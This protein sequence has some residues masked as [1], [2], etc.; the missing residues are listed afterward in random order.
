MTFGL[1]KQG[2][3][4]QKL[5]GKD[6]SLITLTRGGIEGDNNRAALLDELNKCVA[7]GNVIE[8][9][10]VSADQKGIVLGN[11]R[12]GKLPVVVSI[13]DVHFSDFSLGDVHQEESHTVAFGIAR[14]LV[15]DI[16]H[17][18]PGMNKRE[19]SCCENQRQKRKP[20]DEVVSRHS[21]E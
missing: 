4:L 2:K 20:K 6:L 7:E 18:D 16:A 3:L 21:V 9:G 5:P 15:L 19:Q 1:S 14:V 8:P 11:I 13:Q 12:N 17:G 10:A